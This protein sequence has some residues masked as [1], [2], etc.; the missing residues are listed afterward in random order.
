MELVW[1]YEE[2]G[3]RIYTRSYAMPSARRVLLPFGAS[4]S[5][6]KLQTYWSTILPGSKRYVGENEMAGDNTD[7]R[8]PADD[9]IWKGGGGGGAG[10]GNRT[11]A[12]PIK[13]VTLNIDGVFFTDGEF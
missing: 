12:T 10:G 8:L 4:P 1:R 6:L 11:S 13:S 5:S 3:G 9:E 2:A 7:V